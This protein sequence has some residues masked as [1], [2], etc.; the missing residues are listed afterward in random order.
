MRAKVN[1]IIAASAITLFNFGILALNLSVRAKADVAGMDWRD[2]SRD[3]DF[4]KAVQNI[5]G[6]CTVDGSNLSC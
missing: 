2:L 6:N 3:R 4:K 5:V 1:L